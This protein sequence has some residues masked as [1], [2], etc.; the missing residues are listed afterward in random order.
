MSVVKKSTWSCRNRKNKDRNNNVINM[1]VVSWQ[2]KVKN[3][4]HV[5]GGGGGGAVKNTLEPVSPVT[6]RATTG[7]FS[8]TYFPLFTALHFASVL[9]FHVYF[10]LNLL[11]QCEHKI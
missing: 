4:C 8:L 6:F 1:A 7:Y 11:L 2:R 10:F 9:L 3:I 5:R